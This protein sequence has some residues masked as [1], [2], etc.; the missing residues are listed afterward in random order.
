MA[1]ISYKAEAADLNFVDT[2]NR[3]GI[4]IVFVHAFPLNQAMWNEQVKALKGA[5]RVVTFDI[6]GFGKSESTH[7]YTLEFVVD[8]LIDLLDKL[9]INKTVICGLS[10]GGF[11]ALRALERNPNR[12]LAAILAD[13]KSEADSDKSKIGRYEALREIQTSGLSTFV[14]NF[15]KRSAAPDT[16]THNPA[17]FECMIRLAMSNT[18]VGV[19]AGLLALTSRTD[20]T[21]ALEKISVPT[22]VI[23][24]EYDSVISKDSAKALTEKIKGSEFYLV[25]GAG[26]LS[27]LDNAP[28]FNA[29]VLDFLAKLK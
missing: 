11:V 26:H 16:Q 7:P 28:A 8:D 21:Q 5:Y 1:T 13:T 24:G 6:R 25:P 22:L 20:T 27:N 14:D 15:I 17:L 29:R 10:M 23:Q 2:G 3:N 9:K 12:F 18:A 19:Q 4:P